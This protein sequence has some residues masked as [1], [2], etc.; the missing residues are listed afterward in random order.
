MR[1][2][3]KLLVV[4]FAELAGVALLVLLYL[5]FRV[6]PQAPAPAGAPD[7]VAAAAPTAARR[8]TTAPAV[9]ATPTIAAVA[10]VTAAPTERVSQ[11]TVV[12]G[13]T[14]WGVAVLFGLSLDEIVAA[15]PNID[16][17]RVYPGDV[18]NIPGPGTIMVAR[19]TDQPTEAPAAGAP[20][21][22]SVLSAQVGADAGGLRLRKG[23]DTTAAILTKL[24]A[25]TPLNVIGRTTDSFWLEV[26]LSDGT[27]GWVMAQYVVVNGA[28]ADLSVTSDEPAAS[29]ASAST[30]G[31]ASAASQA[32]P[33]DE[34]YLSGISAKAQ[35]IFGAGQGMGNHA[36]VF[37][38]VGDSNT[39]NPAFLQAL[40]RGD[41]NLGEYGYLE[42]TVK[43]FKGSFA[44]SQSSPAAVGGF[45]TTKVL[46]AANSPGSCGGQ[47]PPVCEYILTTPSVALILLGTGDQHTWQGFE[48]RYRQIIEYT[49]AQ[50]I[51]PVLLTKGDDLESRDNTAPQ[52]YI[53]A[54]IARLSR[55][56]DVPLLDLRQAITNL[57]NRGFNS[58]GFHYNTPPDGRS[59]DF[60]GNHMQ[61]GYTIRNL[62]ALQMLDA[63]RRQVLGG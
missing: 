36:N 14:L 44:R 60:T 10:E 28:L 34:P 5:I 57:P 15:N 6:P 61:Y 8:A 3:S 59:C 35:L 29:A 58:D 63:L 53:N 4:A 9:A 26:T 12:E 27:Q 40:D 54:I 30:G 24:P 20:S 32:P 50:G 49:I 1:R 17:D 23:P 31:S 19:A 62:T 52:G 22:P 21:A 38:L 47:T 7:P 11:Y 42:D 16:P 2:P 39:Q 18:L 51:I 37:A 45:N 25:L 33:R 48:G 43:F 56:Y 41:Y 46:D 13:D 55:E